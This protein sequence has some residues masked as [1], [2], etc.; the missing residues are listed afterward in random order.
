MTKAKNDPYRLPVITCD[1]CNFK[2][3]SKLVMANHWSTPLSLGSGPSLRYA[4]HWCGHESKDPLGVSAHIETEH[5]LKSTHL[6]EL[7]PHQC[8]LCPF[9]DAAKSKVTRHAISCQKRFLPERN[10]EPPLDWEPP[11][12]IPRTRGP[13]SY[14]GP[15]MPSIAKGI[16]LP[17]HPLL[18]ASGESWYF[19]LFFRRVGRLTI[20]VFF[21]FR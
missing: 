12:K 1:R 20:D 5:A 19:F 8:P 21:I 2:T 7:A 4:C 14:Q 16:Q 6:P 10:L 18:P 17:Y 15:T 9:E 3:E 13:R 11:A